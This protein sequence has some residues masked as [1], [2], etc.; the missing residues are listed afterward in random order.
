MISRLLFQYRTVLAALPL[1]YALFGRAG[2]VHDP[3]IVLPV[4]ALLCLSG[5]LVRGWS[6]AHCS[7]AMARS[8]CLASTGPY[9]IVRNP[10]YV[11]NLL[12]LAGLTAASGML[13]LV[14]LEIVWG[15][16]VYVVVI[17]WYEEPRLLRWYGEPYRAYREATPAWIP[18][19]SDVARLSFPLPRTS[20]PS[21]FSWAVMQRELPRLLFL[22]P[23]ALKETGWLGIMG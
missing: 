7:Y 8:K 12:M 11:G 2:E 4:T 1:A 10:L 19:W 22:L 9:A 18:R 16:F 15:W 21:V 17:T 13:W 5:M 6:S 3:R 20:V 23:F 14:P